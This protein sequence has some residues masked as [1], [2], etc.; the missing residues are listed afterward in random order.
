M[1]PPNLPSTTE[2]QL[3]HLFEDEYVA[4]GPSW[5]ARICYG[6]GMTYILGLSTG[7][8]WGF[9]DGMRHPAGKTSNRLRF[10]CVLNSCTA[11]G[12]FVANNIGMLALLYNLIHG[13]VIKARNGKYDVYSSV[14]SAAV[15]GVVFKSTAGLRPMGMAG[16]LFGSGMLCYQL[17]K[18]YHDEGFINL[19]P[20]L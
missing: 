5:G 15:A 10:N 2:N 1:Q 12:P 17:A 16:A 11:R 6:T 19:G 20:V 14:G 9:V 4:N 3:E 8:L 7:G 13:G 18:Q